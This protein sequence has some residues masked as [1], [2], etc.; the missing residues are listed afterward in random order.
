[1]VTDRARNGA[2]ERGKRVDES[3]LPD[4]DMIGDTVMAEVPDG[5]HARC[6]RSAKHWQEA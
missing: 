5:L 1:V 6:M 3:G 2:S 4:I